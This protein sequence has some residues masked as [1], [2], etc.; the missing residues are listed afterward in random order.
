MKFKVSETA[1]GISVEI[2]EL[3]GRQGKVLEAF[4]ACSEGNCGCPTNEYKNMEKLDIQMGDE[5]IKLELTAKEG[6]NLNK[7]EIEKC[8]NS[9]IESVG[10]E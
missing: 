4:K 10:S 9:T 7:D 6:L 1:S 8:L 3:D 2:T 5:V